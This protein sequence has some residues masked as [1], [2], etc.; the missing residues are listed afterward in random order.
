MRFDLLLDR[1]AA[2][3]AG[4][5]TLLRRVARYVLP[6][7]VLPLGPAVAQI[8]TGWLGLFAGGLAAMVLL[9]QA[10][11]FIQPSFNRARLIDSDI[12][13]YLG[14]GP[15]PHPP[16][17]ERVVPLIVPAA[18]ALVLGGMLFMPAMLAA[19]DSWQRVL[20]LALAG[21]ALWSVW[22]RLAA[23]VT[24]LESV[25]ERLQAARA[26]LA[27]HRGHSEQ[28]EEGE[29]VFQND[30][31]GNHETISVE[32]ASLPVTPV[33]SVAKLPPDGLLEP[34]LARRALGLPLPALRLSPA[35]I[36]LLRTEAY[37][38][39]R[40][41][42]DT[43]DQSLVRAIAEL[44]QQAYRQELLHSHMPPIGGKIY[45]PV[46]A[47]G[48]V[49]NLLGAT[50]RR[51]AMD[52]AY[53]ASLRT[54]LVRLPPARSYAVAG[55][56]VDAVVA[57][58]ML[59]RGVL[60]H[61]LTVQGD[62]GPE[63]RLLSLLHLAATPLVFEERPGRT[64]DERPFIMRGGG[65]LDDL[66]GRGRLSGPRT[67]FVDGFLFV[68]VPGMEEVEH[69]AGHT[70]NLR[71]KQVLAFGL[72]ANTLPS[73]KRNA[74]EEQAARAFAQMRQELHALLAQHGLEAALEIDWLDGPWS[75][76]WPLIERM[77]RVKQEDPHFLDTGQHIRDTALD[78]IEA[79]ATQ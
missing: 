78:T 4:E 29:G 35:G 11:L 59:P 17:L 65:V 57:L 24:L 15:A 60:P 37:L 33:R 1:L 20:A 64:G 22:S 74:A 68:G 62:L 56:L 66:E 10:E 52:G 53:S 6:L 43:D 9:A 26:E 14:L 75:A 45:L 51:L 49:A 34:E 61:H 12:T 2:S 16:A 73:Y 21:G 31:G 30:A 36:A 76:L 8:A 27:S 70:L 23:A 42:P 44:G 54:W 41:F 5:R 39:L 28:R 7:L 63:A 46:A 79:L 19:A 13:T 50:A 25:T 77:G 48:A 3:V 69:G 38:A 55:R 40:D 58:G 67:D 18:I 32:Q 47:G 72:A 71:L